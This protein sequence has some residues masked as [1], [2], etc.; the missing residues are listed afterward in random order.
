LIEFVKG[1]WAMKF[2][3]AR[4][5]TD[6]QK[7]GLEGQIEALREAGCVDIGKE[8]AIYSEMVSGAAVRR[9]VLEALNAKLRAG[10]VV[11]ATRMDRLARKVT[12][13]LELVEDWSARDIELVILDFAGRTINTKSASDMLILTMFAAFAEFERN[14]MKERQ[15]IGI[16]KAKKDG[17]YRG[18]QPTAMAKAAQVKA[19]DAQGLTRP[20]IA[21][22]LGIGVASVYRALKA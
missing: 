19:L 12:K 6:D 17:K 18:R 9:P 11:V 20:A 10:D 8:K 4:S 3:Y 5:S 1:R 21:A 13:L 22:Q 2:G 14:T 7:Y 15:V 16:A